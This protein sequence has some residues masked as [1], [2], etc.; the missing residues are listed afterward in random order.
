MANQMLA[1]SVED[2]SDD[3]PLEHR[4][5]RLARIRT[6][7]SSPSKPGKLKRIFTLGLRDARW[8]VP[9]AGL[10]VGIVS[11]VVAL[12]IARVQNT[13][14]RVQNDVQGNLKAVQ[15]GVRQIAQGTAF[16][17]T[18]P[19][20]HTRVGE[21][22]V[23]RG[24]TPFPD[25]IH[26]LLVTAGVNDVSW[27]QALPATVSRDGVWSGTAKFGEGDVGVQQRYVV[28]CLATN[29]SLQPGRLAKIPADAL[30]SDPVTVLR[31][32]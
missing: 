18:T 23:I 24:T 10:L 29:E 16:A 8:D 32:Q 20:R 15:S 7:A 26:Y 11:I 30:L 12:Y 4:F 19:Q 13:M 17:I 3:P 25:R 14:A 6:R 1:Q 28:R 27:V 2:E 5:I 22:E 21:T 9:T 31:V